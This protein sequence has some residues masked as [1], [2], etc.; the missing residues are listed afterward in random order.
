[1]PRD[2]LKLW[3]GQ[4]VSLV[5]SEVTLLGMPLVA[6]LALGA[7]AS[8]MGILRA[9]QFAPELLA[10]P[11][12]VLV[13]RRRRRPLLIDTDL[14]QAVVLGSIPLA[15]AVGLLAMRQLYVVALLSGALTVVFGVAYQAYLPALV[16]SAW[17][18]DA[19][20]RLQTSRSAAHA[21]GPAVAGGPDTGTLGARGDRGRCAV[22]CRLVREPGLD[23]V[24]RIAAPTTAPGAIC[25]RRSWTA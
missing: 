1:M 24:A 13:D 2:F 10:L 22:L 15:A 4:S 23:Q 8:E 21:V 14:M 5:G 20:S 11:V 3:V 7:S 18:L 9:L 25:G 19:N 12:G 17:L 6:V 16:P